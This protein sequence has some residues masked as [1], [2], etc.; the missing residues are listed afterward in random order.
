MFNY[1]FVAYLTGEGILTQDQASDALDA[2]QSNRARIGLLAIESKLMEPKDV[3]YVNALQASKNARFG[4][5]AVE[6]GFISRDQFETLL[7]TQLK[8]HVILKQILV[9]KGYITQE[10]FEGA[11]VSFQKHLNVSDEVYESLKDNEVHSYI[12]TI[13]GINP[14]DIVLSKFAELFLTVAS[15]LIDSNIQIKK[16][17]PAKNITLKHVALQCC[18]GDNSY[19]FAFGTDSTK[20]AVEFAKAFSKFPIQDMGADGQDCMKEFLNCASGM[21]ITTLSN[22]RVMELGLEVPNYHKDK[23]IDKIKFV[24]PFSLSMGDFYIT[25]LS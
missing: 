23:T 18:T 16:V 1:I 9:E 25:V 13:V 2:A 11:L 3:E 14:K 22:T 7:R 20:A 12:P 8:S 19:T 4:D 5:I 6:S 17:E 24:I 10:K 21:L 15:R